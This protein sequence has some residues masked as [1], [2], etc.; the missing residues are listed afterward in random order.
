[1]VFLIC[2]HDTLFLSVME[3]NEGSFTV[4]CLQKMDEVTTSMTHSTKPQTSVSTASRTILPSARDPMT[5]SPYSQPQTTPIPSVTSQI[6]TDDEQ[7]TT[8]PFTTGAIVSNDMT[9]E[10]HVEQDDAQGK[11]LTQEI[12]SSNRGTSSKFTCTVHNWNCASFVCY[13]K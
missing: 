7:I 13:L 9:E 3:N 4:K 5:Q 2:H 8:T 10:P 11:Q 6:T 1:M 12:N